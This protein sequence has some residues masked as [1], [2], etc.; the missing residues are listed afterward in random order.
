MKNFS[1]HIAIIGAG[2]SGLTLGC[3][4]KKNGISVVIFEKSSTVSEQG[5]GISISPNG[6]QVLKKIGIYEQLK[7]ES[8]SAK[9]TNL[10]YN[11]EEL[12]SFS[13]NVITTTRQCLYNN[14]LDKYRSYDGEIL[15]D[16][17][18]SSINLN[19]PEISFL[20]QE[21]VHV[22]HIAA[23]DGIRSTCK[24]LIDNNYEEPSYSGYSV[25]RA[26]LDKAQDNIEI[27]LGPNYHIVTY[28]VNQKRTSFVAAIKDKVQAKDSWRSKGSYDDL[29]IDLPDVTREIY[30]S[31]DGSNEIYKWGVYTK[32]IPSKLFD[33]NITFLGDAAHPITPFMGQGGCL[34]L[35]DAYIFAKLLEL[36]NE[37]NVTQQLYQKL[38]LDRVIRIH[39][40]SALQGKLNHIANP[41]LIFCRNLLMKYSPVASLRPTSIWSYDPDAEI[42]KIT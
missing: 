16:H 20:N 5:A 31:L 42:S 39:K 4:L 1:S 36:D 35:E 25:W 3:Q 6:L 30:S 33:T 12:T 37:I 8:G 21:S 28:P 17:E 9:K 26:I 10:L 18:V 24:R 14:L 2:I 13:V 11:R 7:N 22:K 27:H 38:R 32:K 15:F 34:A 19:K 41:F 23:C 40:S 29:C